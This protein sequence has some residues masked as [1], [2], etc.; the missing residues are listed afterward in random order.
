LWTADHPG[1][2][3]LAAAKL[4]DE[5][6]LFD[7]PDRFVVHHAGLESPKWTSKLI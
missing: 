1:G 4:L 7:R 3:D 6:G 2:F 5:D